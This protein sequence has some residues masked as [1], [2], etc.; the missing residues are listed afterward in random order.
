MTNQLPLALAER[1][2]GIARVSAANATFLETWRAEARRIARALHD[3]TITADDL[4]EHAVA[5]PELPVPTHFNAWGPIFARNEDF[6]FVGYTKSR[7]PRG[8]AI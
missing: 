8:M 3:R 4:R 2:R 6:E 5:H 7:Q 1:D